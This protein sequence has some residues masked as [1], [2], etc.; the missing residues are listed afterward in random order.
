MKRINFS[1]IKREEQ[2][3]RKRYEAFGERVFFD[4]LKEQ[5]KDY[6]NFNPYLMESAYLRFYESVFVDSAKRG[7]RIAREINKK[8]LLS[9]AFFLATWRGW[10]AQYVAES[11]VMQSLIKNV[12]DRTLEMIATALGI[13]IEQGL[14][15]ERITDSIVDFVASRSR[16]KGI[17][18][19][20]TTRATSEGKKQSALTWSQE[21]GAELWKLWVHS[22]NPNEPRFNHID[23]Q[24]R[25]IREGELFDNGLDKPGDPNGDPAET[26]RCGCTI[27]YVSGDYVER[28]YP[29]LLN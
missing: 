3:A 28:F 25:P 17:A 26:V 21:T 27:V 11:V 9:E 22:G 29:D 13:A 23:L 18:V 24:D 5:A 8:E 16:A 10:I 12:N 2:F 1:K 15:T 4:A 6:N 7:L 20:E 14:D 19:T